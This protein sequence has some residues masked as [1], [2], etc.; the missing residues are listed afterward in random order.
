MVIWKRPLT[1][2]IVLIFVTQLLSAEKK[3]FPLKGQNHFIPGIDKYHVLVKFN[4]IYNP[5]IDSRG[6]LTLFYKRPSNSVLTP[7]TKYNLTFSRAI[8]FSP[9]QLKKLRTTQ[10]N[11]PDEKG[12]N[13]LDFAGLLY[14]KNLYT[15]KVKL[16]EICNALKKLDEVEYAELQ[17]QHEFPPPGDIPLTTPELDSA[18]GYRKPDP[19]ID[20][21]YAWS[22]GIKG[23]G[24]R[25]CDIEYY[26]GTPMTH[27]EFVDQDIEF[28]LPMPNGTSRQAHAIAVLGILIAGENGYGI[29]GAAPQAKGFVAPE[30]HGR[31]T[32]ALAAIDSMNEGDVILYEMQT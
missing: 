19:G 28:V 1:S 18:Q 20:I 23:E 14:V 3:N 21:E 32:A 17:P 26:R 2:I 7:I 10:R 25:I 4:T 9:Q 30:E 27:E 22:E 11:E 16:L 6:N 29:H 15:N 12:F 8:Q 5:D 31:A 13:I 24:I